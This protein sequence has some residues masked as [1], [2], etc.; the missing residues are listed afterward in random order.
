MAEARLSLE[1]GGLVNP[2]G[3]GVWIQPLGTEDDLQGPGH[4]LVPMG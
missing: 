1:F 4:S 3:P 2:G